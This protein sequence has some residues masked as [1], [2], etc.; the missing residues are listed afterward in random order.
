[1]KIDTIL[2]LLSMMLMVHPMSCAN[3]KEA[4]KQAK[5][6]AKSR[7]RDAMWPTTDSPPP[8]PE[9]D[10]LSALDHLSKETQLQMAVVLQDIGPF[11]PADARS[12]QV[13]CQY[14]AGSYRQFGKISNS[15]LADLQW[16]SL[17][18]LS[19]AEQGKR[20]ALLMLLLNQP[21][22]VTTANELSPGILELRDAL[23]DAVVSGKYSWAIIC[24]DLY[25][26]LPD[27]AAY[28]LCVPDE[29]I[30][31]VGEGTF[32]ALGGWKYMVDLA[33]ELV[34]LKYSEFG[35]MRIKG[36]EV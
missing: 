16:K 17:G 7:I 4:R 8:D 12:S 26:M 36:K 29:A 35:P 19:T 31:L 28:L 5:R 15:T 14:F 25:I 9:T 32:K 27:V 33:V 3:P 2:P 22:L 18:N 6:E 1:M 24:F 11:H 34:C 10:P 21:L 13:F 23:K 20:I 30:R